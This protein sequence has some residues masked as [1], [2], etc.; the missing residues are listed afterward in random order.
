MEQQQQPH[1]CLRTLAPPLQ[2]GLRQ[3]PGLCHQYQ[4]R[5]EAQAALSLLSVCTPQATLGLPREPDTLAM[6]RHEPP[7]TP[8]LA[9]SVSPARWSLSSAWASS[10]RR[11]ACHAAATQGTTPPTPPS[12]PV[13]GGNWWCN[14]CRRPREECECLCVIS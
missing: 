1:S 9:I 5:E 11:K 12:T 6:E 10:S 14:S 7:R 8:S 13:R 4:Y 2:P 3:Q